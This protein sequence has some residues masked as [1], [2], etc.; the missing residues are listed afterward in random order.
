MPSKRSKPSKKAVRARNGSAT[1]AA[2]ATKHGKKTAR[3]KPVSKKASTG[4]AVA[5]RART[6]AAKKPVAKKRAATKGARKKPAISK[7]PA[8]LKKLAVSKKPAAPGVHKAVRRAAVKGTSSVR[9]PVRRRDGSGH[10][11]PGYA[12]ELLERSGERASGDKAFIDGS[13]TDDDLAE[14]LGEEAVETMTS[15]EDEG[16]DVADQN[17]PEERGGPFVVTTAGTEF[18]D[19]VDASNPPNA[20]REPFPTT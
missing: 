14:E 1:R 19:G 8:V 17:V 10:I 2:L 11:E 4:R 3:T 5:K 9:A 15:G 16:E 18:A 7:K 13:H 20:K 12:K 6:V